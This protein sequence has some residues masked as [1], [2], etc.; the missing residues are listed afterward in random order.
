MRKA[1]RRHFRPAGEFGSLL[2]WAACNPRDGGE[3]RKT[4]GQ[5]HQAVS[6]LFLPGELHLDFHLHLISFKMMLTLVVNVQFVYISYI[7]QLLGCNIV[8]SGFRKKSHV[9][10]MLEKVG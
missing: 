4:L 2:G 5:D 7:F 10:N 6:C 3:R 9:K 1:A 8:L